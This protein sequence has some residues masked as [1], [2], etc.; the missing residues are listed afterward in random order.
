MEVFQPHSLI[1][2]INEEL[3][4]KIINICEN[5][6]GEICGFIVKDKN[7][8]FNFIQVKN[9]HPFKDHHFLISPLDFLQIKKEYII[10]Y[11]F[12]SHDDNSLFS[13]Q[14]RYHQKFHNLNMLLLCKK[15]KIWSEMKCK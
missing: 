3:K 5:E 9:K 15:T 10:E 13:D 1:K 7:N 11:L 2:M 12:H 8:S 14:D 6:E 4:Q